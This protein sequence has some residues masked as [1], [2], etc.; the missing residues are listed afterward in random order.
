MPRKKRATAA[1]PEGPE[2]VQAVAAVLDP[3]HHSMPAGQAVP[4]EVQAMCIEHFSASAQASAASS[5]SASHEV[6]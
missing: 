3:A 5:A 2:W 4:E 1:Q 6:P